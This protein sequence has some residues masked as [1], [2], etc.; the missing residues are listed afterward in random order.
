M[1]RH[2]LLLF[3]FLGTFLYCGENM[4]KNPAM[5]YFV[6]NR[7][8]LHWGFEPGRSKAY[9]EQ[10]TQDAHSGKS[11]LKI[12]NP[13]PFQAHVFGS[14]VQR[15][16]GV[17]PGET[18]TISFY[19]KSKSPGVVWF[20]GGAAWRVRFPLKLDGEEWTRVTGTFVAEERDI[21]FVFRL[22]TDSQ[23]DQLLVDDF[24]MELGGEATAFEWV[25]PLEP[26]QSRLILK[27][28]VPGVNLLGNPSFEKVSS[29]RPQ[30]W[31]WDKRNTDS[32]FELLNEDAADGSVA[33]RLTNK[34]P[35]GPHVYGWFGHQGSIAVGP[36]TKYTFAMTVRTKEEG[37][38][39]FGGGKDWKRR[40]FIP[41]THGEWQRVTNTFV[42]EAD[43]TEFPFMLILE[44][45]CSQLDIDNA[46]FVEGDLCEFDWDRERGENVIQFKLFPPERFPYHSSFMTPYWDAAKY[47]PQDWLFAKDELEFNGFIGLRDGIADAEAFVEV[48]DAKSGNVLS[49]CRR[50]LPL[51]KDRAWTVLAGFHP[52]KTTADRI[53]VRGVL[54]SGGKELNRYERSFGLVTS[55][56][57][58]ARAASLQ[59]R[60]QALSKVIEGMK[61]LPRPSMLR[62]SLT[63]TERFLGYIEGDLATGQLNRAWF[64]LDKLE[65]ILTE[66]EAEAEAIKAGRKP[67]PPAVPVYQTSPI[68][69][70]KS[71]NLA[72][73]KMPDGTLHENYPVFFTGYGHFTTVRRD[74]ERFPD[75]GMNFFQIE[76][77]PW[78]VLRDEHT[79][80][81]SSFEGIVEI[82]KRA[83]AS[84][85]KMNL[86]LSPHYFPDWAV[87]K[88][89]ELAKCKAGVL[90]MCLHSAEGRG[91]VEKYL[92]AVIPLVKDL[93]ALHSFCLTNEPTSRDLTGCPLVPGLWRE[94]LKSKHGTIGVLNERWLSKYGSFDEIPVP[95]PFP[96]IQQIPLS[97]DFILFN[98]EALADFHAWMADVIHDMAPNVPVHS[99]IMMGAHFRREVNGFWSVS[100]ELFSRFSQFHG[101][102][103]TVNE[104]SRGIYKS[105]WQAFMG[106][107]FQRSFKDMPVFNSENHIIPD[108]CFT[109][110]SPENTY[111]ALMQGAIHGMSSTTIWVWERTN[112]H[113]SDLAGSILHRPKHVMAASKAAM[114]LMRLAPE[115]TALQQRKPKVAIVWSIASI[116]FNEDKHL[117]VMNRIWETTEFLDQPTGFLTERSLAQI[118]KSGKFP[119]RLSDVK[120]VICPGV[121][122]LPDDALAGLATLEKLGCRKLVF[123][124]GTVFDEYNRQREVPSGDTVIALPDDMDARLQ[125]I[126]EQLRGCGLTSRARFL[127]GSGKPIFGVQVGSAEVDG[128]VVVNV[129]NQLR[130]PAKGF[131]ELDGKPLTASR[132]LIDGAECGRELVIKPL[133]VM[134]LRPVK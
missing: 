59:S 27:P 19:A 26:G 47:P 23:T 49:S 41:N 107:D 1:T 38:G 88:N 133:Q 32:T 106:Y 102:D 96:S 109:D 10:Y 61:D 46:Q 25:A 97:Y 134:Y 100:P 111:M 114:D 119:D 69:L 55:D 57:I 73:V 4:F 36:L 60:L 130:E 48:L 85:V 117:P 125:V 65:D 78:D 72:T 6:S 118:A 108:R 29:V 45:P 75:Y 77:G 83:A 44:Y 31:F 7:V 34:T 3:V 68:T 13:S 123:G 51:D 5:E 67:M 103:N 24:K 39:W 80:D 18:Y 110:L 30:N 28:F 93:P 91:V 128:A 89:P 52:G 87:K 82:G 112:Q 40:Q 14:L 8:P 101:N 120:V 81:V 116:L 90:R 95:S 22:N 42:T 113:T 20:G 115:V 53:L 126:G 63:V 92:R 127:D 99:K 56:R 76:Q 70:D 35:G 11:C 104:H 21:P 124:S 121:V 94:W 37:R 132:D 122:N 17:K 2:V 86:L 58:L 43:E 105:G 15:I 16:D 33:I 71:S 131:L 64:T 98:Q 62:L 84:N 79:V 129:C 54:S 66:Y 12:V 74:V 9:C 50:S